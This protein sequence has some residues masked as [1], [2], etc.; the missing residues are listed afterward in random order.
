M[1]DAA[2]A[3]TAAATV[4]AALATIAETIV[5]FVAAGEYTSALDGR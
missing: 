2:A 5:F 1:L 4:Y 3:G